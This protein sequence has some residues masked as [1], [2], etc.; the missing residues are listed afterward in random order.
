MWASQINGPVD[1]YIIPLEDTFLNQVVLG[2]L[3]A[4]AAAPML[5]LTPGSPPPG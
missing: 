4:T 2:E 3:W 5:P 1:R